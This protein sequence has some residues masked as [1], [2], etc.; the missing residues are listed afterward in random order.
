MVG[1]TADV[2]EG[3]TAYCATHCSLL[4]THGSLLTGPQRV[5]HAEVLAE[6]RAEAHVLTVHRHRC[7]AHALGPSSDADLRLWCTTRYA[8][9]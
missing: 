5:L 2:R 1:S 9:R 8:P 3:L 4:T 7:L 6:R